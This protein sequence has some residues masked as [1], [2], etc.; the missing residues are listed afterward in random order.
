MPFDVFISHS[1][2]DKAA[3]DAACSAL[4]S[5]GIRCWIAPRDVAPGADWAGA[6]VNSIDHCR[7]MVVIFSSGANQSK[8]I[9]REVQ[10]AFERE[11]PVIPF[12]IENV[13]PESTLA[14]YMGPVHW[15]DALTPPL[16]N[17]LKQL[18]A[19]VS[20]ILQLG[21]P[22]GTAGDL[23]R[24]NQTTATAN[25]E[26][27]GLTAAPVQMPANPS[28]RW[29]LASAAI[30]GLAIVAAAG[31]WSYLQKPAPVITQQQPKSISS[32]AAAQQQPPP[33][34]APAPAV[35]Q[36][37]PPPA[38]APSTG[39][40]ATGCS[41]PI[42]GNWQGTGSTASTQFGGSPY[43]TYAVSL[44]KPM[45]SVSIDEF[46]Q[47]SAASLA[48]TMVE[49]IAGSCPYPPLGTQP[50]SY[51]GGGTTNAANVTLELNPAPGNKP[52]AVAKFSGAVV[53]G[54]LVGTLTVH[55]INI[56]AIL[57]WT[58]ESSIR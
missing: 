41:S 33:A 18:V 31:L 5:A 26:R 50:Q 45:L 46:G 47:V 24:E 52:S 6:I 14:Y 13:I 8:Q 21:N 20:T 56:A 40:P 58:V 9:Y 54:R 49:S 28:P 2:Q 11:L 39:A 4:E 30:I 12:R 7:A 23:P 22:A 44:E 29:M 36:Q 55:R 53:N 15:L 27:L 35:T 3:A 32:P 1:H 57:A 25:V 17:H 34:P 38:P 48:L 51:Q 37:Q 19:S 10:R 42:C 16:E 43:C